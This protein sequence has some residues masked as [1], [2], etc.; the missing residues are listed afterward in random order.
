MAWLTT[1]YGLIT[2]R[3]MIY[4]KLLFT[5]GVFKMKTL[6]DEVITST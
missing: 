3:I 4:L 6:R 2:F 5:D 1:K